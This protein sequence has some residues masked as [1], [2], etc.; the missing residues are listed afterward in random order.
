VGFECGYK[1]G[2]GTHNI[3]GLTMRRRKTVWLVVIAIAVLFLPA[4]VY[5]QTGAISGQARDQ[6]DAALPGVTVEV[7]SPALIEKVRSTTTDSNGRYQIT[8]LPVG[9][10]EVNFTLTGFTPFKR[11][12]VVVTSDFNANVV[13]VMKVGA[14][15]AEVNVVGESPIVDVQRAQQQIVFQ[16]ADI[17]ELPTTR[18]LPDIMT[19]VPGLTAPRGIGGNVNCVGGTATGTIMCDPYLRGFNAHA[20]VN[21]A[22]AQAQGRVLV[23]GIAINGPRG[24]LDPFGFDRYDG[25][26]G[27]YIADVGGAQEVSF[28]LSGA[29]GESETGGAAINIVPRTGG[30][31]FAGN[32]FLSY[33]DEQFFDRNR[34]T[35]L[36]GSPQTVPVDFD[37]DVNGSFGG[38]VLRDRF[39][40]YLNARHQGKKNYL[41]PAQPFWWNKNYGIWGKNYQPDRDR[42]IEGY[43]NEYKNASLRLTIQAS[44][45]N[46]F[47]IFWDEQ[48][49]C[50]DPCYGVLQSWTSPESWQSTQTWPNR[51]IQLRWTNPATNRLLLDGN[52]SMTLQH[53]DTS[54][55]REIEDPTWVPRISETGTTA[56][57]DEISIN[58]PIQSVNQTSGGGS[59]L[60]SGSKNDA[61]NAGGYAARIRN[62]DN[63]RSS[64]SVSYI[65]GSHNAKIGYEG[66]YFMEK[67]TPKV[68]D[69]RLTI[70]M[71]TPSTTC[72][73]NNSCG[74]TS[75]YFPEDPNN[76]LY[77]RPVPTSFT[78]NTGTATLDE[79]VWFGALYIQDS[80]TLNRVTLSG[81]LRYDHAQSRYGQTCVG[82][83]GNEPYVPVQIGGAY[84]GLRYWCTE[85]STGVNFNDITPRW[86]VAWDVFGNGRTSVK[87]NMGK[88]LTQA[89]FGGVYSD[90]NA[91]A[92]SQ[93]SLNRGWQD[94]NGNRIPDCRFFDFALHTDLGDTCNAV[95]GNT[96]NRYGRDPYA[97]DAAGLNAA[98]FLTTQ[99][100]RHDQASPTV[101]SYCLTSGDNL[102]SG[103]GARRYEWQLGIGV[104]HEL[105][106][107]LSVEV[108][109]NR[110]RY[111][112]MTQNDVLGRGCDR[113][114]FGTVPEDVCQTNYLN[115]VA[116]HHD[117]Y[118]IQVPIDTRLP[119]G[120]G[121]LLR[122]ITTQ[123]QVGALPDNGTAV[124]FDSDLGYSWAGIDTNFVLRARGGLR[125]SGGTSTGRSVRD[126]CFSTL[127][128]PDV[129]GR[130]GN[131]YRA[132]CRSVNAL[133]TNVRA[134]AAYTIPV[135]D[136][137]S[138]VVFQYRPGLP[139]SANLTYNNDDV[140]W[141]PA[142][143]HRATEACTVNNAPDVGCF[144]GNTATNTATV[145]LLD[146]GDLY[147]EG[148]R[149]FDLRF[150]KNIRIA[151][152]RL[153]IGVDVYNLFNSDA[154]TSYNNTYTAWRDP[155]TGTWYQGLGPEGGRDNPATAAQEVQN[156]G[157]VN[158]VMSP[159]FLRF[160][161]QFDF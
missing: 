12:S 142:S 46:K 59:T 28:T 160:Q 10:Y 37:Y 112:N 57:I 121:Y 5:A 49:S 96:A 43:R 1:A 81:A 119:T 32:F 68:N 22:S 66:A 54:Y 8:A 13:G 105:L 56:G 40:F 89:G 76:T 11:S 117:F 62:S 152:K 158:G 33:A 6:S 29:L 55:H 114:D 153:N 123:K 50:Q 134:N 67:T 130:E 113:F 155:A 135:I 85:P 41:N 93:Y 138:S 101:Q 42:Q 137:L 139:R 65:T 35:R 7:T 48:S 108:T 83:E 127:D 136:V 146:S 52:L 103:W 20:D 145:N 126:T 86:N 97:L 120:G 94:N 111:G 161:V 99:C 39:W 154:A 75:R 90:V 77:R 150:G 30:N 16:G 159:R 17:R 144:Y 129:R 15:S 51:L 91:A 63:V 70:F 74:N 115:Y 80:W 156:W 23:D 21:D 131:N 4:S 58:L 44:Q 25:V 104:Q 88:F 128:T 140:I 116:P 14:V 61:L 38:P 87:F 141:E 24:A 84:N 18:N 72:A 82:G 98:F 125:L 45:K 53:Y 92:R 110:R 118:A 71:Q 9:T 100:G 27:G 34:D 73:N 122:G 106:P 36:L 107:R 47:N 64:L 143:A 78:I 109:Y 102:V 60:L 69:P 148:I 26:T 157:T 132:G 19:L 149:E 147:G 124:A 3:E 151:G 95:T 79:R 133:Q 2:T 31:R